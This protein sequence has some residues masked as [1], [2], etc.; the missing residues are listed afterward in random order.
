MIEDTA[1]KK[2]EKQDFMPSKSS[3]NIGMIGFSGLMGSLGLGVVTPLMSIY[4]ETIKFTVPEILFFPLFN[5]CILN[6]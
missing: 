5:S 2:R 6:H 4:F 1:V 3:R